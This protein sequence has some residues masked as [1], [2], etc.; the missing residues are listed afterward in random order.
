MA[1]PYVCIG[2]HAFAQKKNFWGTF[3]TLYQALCIGYQLSHL[4]CVA[5]LLNSGALWR[6]ACKLCTHYIDDLL[7]GHTN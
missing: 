5:L 6:V 4:H 7:S 1:L 3:M 2:S